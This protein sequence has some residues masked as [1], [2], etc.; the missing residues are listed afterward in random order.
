MLGSDKLAEKQNDGPYI[1]GPDEDIQKRAAVSDLNAYNQSYVESR[2]QGKP[3][4]AQIMEQLAEAFQQ[5]GHEMPEIPEDILCPITQT[6]FNVPIK[7]ITIIPKSDK[8]T[9][10]HEHFFDFSTLSK[11]NK[12]NHATFKSQNIFCTHPLNRLP[13]KA[14]DLLPAPEIQEKIDAYIEL[15]K[16]QLQSIPSAAEPSSST[17]SSSRAKYSRSFK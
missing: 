11:F 4:N 10:K 2:R 6:V 7:V 16:R 5:Q 15:A 17:A 8:S 1:Q 3:F 13:I 14:Y 12:A 9:E